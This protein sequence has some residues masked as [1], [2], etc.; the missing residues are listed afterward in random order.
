[1][2]QEE[3]NQLVREGKF[4]TFASIPLSVELLKQHLKSL[5]GVPHV[6]R[7]DF[8]TAFKKACADLV[9]HAPDPRFAE[10]YV[11]YETAE[12]VILSMGIVQRKDPKLDSSPKDDAQRD[13]RLRSQAAH[14]VAAAGAAELS[15]PNTTIEDFHRVIGAAASPELVRRML[16][17][18]QASSKVITLDGKRLAPIEFPKRRLNSADDHHIRI[19]IDEVAAS[20]SSAL[21]TI[22][23]AKSPETVS[24]RDLVGRR[25]RLD[26][27]RF[28]EVPNIADLLLS[29]RLVRREAEVIVAV[30]R[31]LRESD[32]DLDVLTLKELLGIKALAAEM[33]ANVE[34]VQRSL[35]ESLA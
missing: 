14:R 10:V 20:G 28:D 1:M 26:V 31:A 18:P 15:R 12:Q 22:A 32:K 8:Q 35:W 4:A 11:P 2:N 17:S 34:Q 7:T 13:E 24:L 21:V 9:V 3:K 6:P 16:T 25:V 33:P 30:T 5:D 19:K 23:W 29:L 27:R